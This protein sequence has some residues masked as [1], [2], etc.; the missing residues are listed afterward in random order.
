MKVNFKTLLKVGVFIFALYLCIHYWQTVA[1]VLGLVWGAFTPLFVGLSLALIVNVPMSFFERHYFPRSKRKLAALTRRPVCLFVS[2]LCFAAV[3][4]LVLWVVIP[5]LVS[6]IEVFLS[7]LPEWGASLVETLR[8]IRFIPEEFVASLE[9]I[10]WRGTVG[11]LLTNIS[12]GLGGVFDAVVNTVSSVF[13]G[14]FTSVVGFVLSVYLL[15]GKERLGRQFGRLRAR[16]LPAKWNRRLTVCGSALYLNFRRYLVGQATEAV[17][18]GTLCTLGM[19]I[20]GMPH[21]TMVGALIAV[22]AFIP[23][24]GPIIAGAIGALMIAS[25][26]PLQAVFFVIFLVVLQQIEGN[27]IYPRVVGAKMGL[28]AIWILASVTV[29]GGIFGVFG[30]VLSVP[31]AATVYGYLREKTAEKP[32]VSEPTPSEQ[33]S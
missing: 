4:T 1:G 13:S 30:M 7:K 28:P 15:S 16:F 6:C 11:E 5:Q 9:A 21:A 10:D 2:Y 3:L 29:G 12:E 19:L 31:V 27:L 32:P 18:L 26:S 25:V 22:L 20:F 17:I 24:I 23:L 8:G 14:L 33:T